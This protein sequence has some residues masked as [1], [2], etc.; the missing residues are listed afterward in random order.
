M[1][2]SPAISSE[3]YLSGTYTL[4]PQTSTKNSGFT[5]KVIKKPEQRAPDRDFWRVDGSEARI[6]DSLET[7]VTDTLNYF[8]VPFWI[9]NFGWMLGTETLGPKWEALSKVKG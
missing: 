7:P 3:D 9:Q 2:D 4:F 8:C 1:I 5:G 6:I